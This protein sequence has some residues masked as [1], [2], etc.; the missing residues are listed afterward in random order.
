MARLWPVPFPPDLLVS[1]STLSHVKV[2][3]LFLVVI[4]ACRS[5]SSTDGTATGTL[6]YVEIDVAP[7]APGRV[8]KVNRREGEPVRIG[9]TLVVLTDRSLAPN[10]DAMQARVRTADAKLR[11][12][13]A[14]P[15]KTDIERLEAE[16]RAAQSEA[17]RTESDLERLTPLGNRGDISKQQFD[18]SKAA[19]NTAAAKRDAAAHALSTLKAGA[20]TEEIDAARSELA[21]AQAAVRAATAT[22]SA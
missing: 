21:N 2:R 22:E 11:Q 18:A 19:A 6:Q 17:D 20:R 14:G 10:V 7:V 5:D 1:P 3:F 4:A 13:L 9:D 16:V 12:L 8:V 15:R